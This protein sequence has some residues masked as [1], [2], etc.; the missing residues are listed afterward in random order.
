M[1]Q[2]RVTLGLLVH[3]CHEVID[4]PAAVSVD[5]ITGGDQQICFG[6]CS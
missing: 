5:S 4:M 2:P 1:R 3:A 6:I